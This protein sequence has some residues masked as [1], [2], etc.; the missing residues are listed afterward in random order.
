MGWFVGWIND[1]I[2]DKTYVF[3]Y[4]MQD[5]GPEKTIAGLRAKEAAMAKISNFIEKCAPFR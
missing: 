2:D 5:Q 1:P 3:A 4:F